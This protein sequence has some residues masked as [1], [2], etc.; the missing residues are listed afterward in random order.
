ME[1]MLIVCSVDYISLNLRH[2]CC[3]SSV[4]L[5]FINLMEDIDKICS[6]KMTS[7]PVKQLITDQLTVCSSQFSNNNSFLVGGRMERAV[8]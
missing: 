3:L 5:M 2:F 7:Y 6:K 1:S 8:T 4:F